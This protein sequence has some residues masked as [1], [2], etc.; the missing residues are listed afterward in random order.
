MIYIYRFKCKCGQML[1]YQNTPNNID[2][3]VYYLTDGQEV[4]ALIR[5]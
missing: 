3:D 5:T 4:Y 2:T 1:S